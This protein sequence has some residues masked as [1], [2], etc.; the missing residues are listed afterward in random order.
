MAEKTAFITGVTGQDGSYLAELLLERGYRV[1]GLVSPEHD[2]GRANIRHLEKELILASGDLL[3]RD[4]L[5]SVL[6]EYRPDEIYNLAA[7][8]FVPSSWD[9]PELV[10]DINGLGV[11]R[12]LSAMKEIVPGSR[13]YQA[14]SSK[15]FGDPDS[16]PQDEST[17]FFPKDPYA[18]AKVYAHRLAVAYREKFHFFIVGG[19][20]YNHESPRRGLQFVSRKISAAAVLIKNNQLERL[21]LGNLEAEEDWGFAGDYVRAIH[22]MMQAGQARDYIVATGKLRSVRDL[23]DA[24]FSC[25]DLSYQDYVVEDERFYRPKRAV[26]LVG[27]AALI[28]EELGWRPEVSFEELVAMMVRADVARYEKGE[29]K[30]EE[31]TG[32]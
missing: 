3:D 7:L 2:I 26:P 22:L 17:P 11:A 1:V 29:L 31:V 15:M 21:S 12:L 30:V 4:S 28:T 32:V 20:L 23:C 6:R 10:G 8:T 18:V 27:D 14:S 24:A 5:T 19:I 25:L 16:A 13:F 9:Q